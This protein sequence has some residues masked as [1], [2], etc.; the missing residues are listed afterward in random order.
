M[1]VLGSQ[2][3]VRS[4]AFR[5]SSSSRRRRQSALPQCPVMSGFVR[6]SSTANS[7]L[8]VLVRSSPFGVPPLAL[9]RKSGVS[10][11]SGAG[12]LGRPFCPRSKTL[13]VRTAQAHAK[14]L[15]CS[16]CLLKRHPLSTKWA[17]EAAANGT[18]EEAAKKRVQ[19]ALEKLRGAMAKKGVVAGVGALGVVMAENVTGAG[20]GGG[21][22]GSGWE[23]RGGIG[24][25]YC[26]RSD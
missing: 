25:S 24:G 19:R 13:G 22:D 12:R 9:Q 10:P 5:R 1:G 16:A 15:P 8:R 23:W 11:Q 26:E 21:G 17:A 4:S 2:F 7:L 3:H 14:A 18:G 20:G 6:S